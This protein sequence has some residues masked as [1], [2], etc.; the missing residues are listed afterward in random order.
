VYAIIE[1]HARGW[2]SA[3]VLGSFGA[4]LVLG[5]VFLARELRAEDPMLPLRFLRERSFSV[6][7]IGIG[8]SSRGCPRAGTGCASA[9]GCAG[10]RSRS[11]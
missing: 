8:L 7:S 11:S 4:A 3:V 10:G 6:G 1:A 2:T 9:C 5:A